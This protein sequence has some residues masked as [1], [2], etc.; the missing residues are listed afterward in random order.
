[1]FTNKPLSVYGLTLAVLLSFVFSMSANASPRNKNSVITKTKTAEETRQ[2]QLA[3]KALIA[4]FDKK[5]ASVKAKYSSEK[6]SGKAKLVKAS[7]TAANYSDYD[8][9]LHVTATAYTSHADQTDSTPNIAA[10]GDRLKPGMKAIAVSR[11][12][13]KVHGLKHK[14]KVRIKGLEGEYVVLDKMNKRWR[15]KI[16]IYMGMNKR[17]AFKWGRRK[18]EILWNQI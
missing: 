8:K 2:L 15:K 3:Y 10:W 9:S 16:D 5:A 18:V 11:D 17:K 1:M 12:L 6:N 14:Q 7:L 13:L 4:E